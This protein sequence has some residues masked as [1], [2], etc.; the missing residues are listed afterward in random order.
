MIT[1]RK[2][3]ILLAL[4]VLEGCSYAISPEVL[5]QADRSVTYEQLQENPGRHKGKTIV[6]GG[7]IAS[8]L[9]QKNG[10]IIEIAEKKLDYWGKPRRTDRSSGLFHVL[11]PQYIDPLLYAP[12]RDITVAGEV[13]G[14]DDPRAEGGS[15]LLLLRSRELKVWPREKLTWDKPQWMDPLYDRTTPQGQYGY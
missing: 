13:V 12:G 1:F 6:L 15:G 10:A 9:N 7:T 11:H 3:L 4:T 2:T 8:V 14:T 5:R